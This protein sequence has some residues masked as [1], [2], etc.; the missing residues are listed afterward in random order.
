MDQ[1]SAPGLSSSNAASN[2]TPGPAAPPP[3]TVEQLVA[4]K[5]EWRDTYARLIDV[6]IKH[7]RYPPNLSEWTAKER[8]E[9]RE[10]RHVI[11]DVL[12]DCVKG[13][14]NSIEFP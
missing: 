6:M 3:F 9:F 14:N 5:L 12:K 2:M 8:D 11:G 7:L 4:R 10:F 1:S 13:K